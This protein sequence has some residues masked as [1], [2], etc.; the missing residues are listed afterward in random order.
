M[1][2]LHTDAWSGVKLL[3]YQIEQSGGDLPSQERDD[4]PVDGRCALVGLG[5]HSCDIDFD[6]VAPA[7]AGHMIGA[8]ADRGCTVCLVLTMNHGDQGACRR[9]VYRIEGEPEAVA[10]IIGGISAQVQSA[11]RRNPLAGWTYETCVGFEGQWLDAGHVTAGHVAKLIRREVARTSDAMGVSATDRKVYG[12]VV[13]E[14]QDLECLLLY[15]GLAPSALLGDTY[16]SLLIPENASLSHGDLSG[17]LSAIP[18]DVVRNYAM[19]NLRQEAEFDEHLRNAKASGPT[20]K[21]REALRSGRELCLAHLC[22]CGMWDTELDGIPGPLIAQQTGPWLGAPPSLLFRQ[23]DAWHAW[24]ASR[25]AHNGLAMSLNVGHWDMLPNLTPAELGTAA[26]I[27]AILETDQRRRTLPGLQTNEISR[28]WHDRYLFAQMAM[29][30]TLSDRAWHLNEHQAAMS[31]AIEES[32][33]SQPEYHFL[34]VQA[35]PLCRA[36]GLTHTRTLEIFQ[37]PTLKF[38]C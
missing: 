26:L 6:P 34:S 17:L 35:E 20:L 25:I 29:A 18:P 31:A 15:S 19:A 16:P 12:V 2:A 13:R 22:T 38:R 30:R 4:F 23:D 10:W 1:I 27:D 3:E 14:Q 32:M 7:D 33:R 36:L 11:I 8:P 5:D 28:T 24:S 37:E 21:V 9:E